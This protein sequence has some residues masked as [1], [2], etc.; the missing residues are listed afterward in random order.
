MVGQLQG[1]HSRVCN[2][3]RR[4]FFYGVSPNIQIFLRCLVKN[5][6]H[7]PFAMELMEHPFLQEVPEDDGM[8][9]KNDEK[10]LLREE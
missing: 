6:D 5:P 1:L 2:L 3:L 4:P 8:V 10:F 7:R 9:L